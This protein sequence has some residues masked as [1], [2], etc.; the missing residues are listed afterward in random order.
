MDDTRHAIVSVTSEVFNRPS[1]CPIGSK[2]DKDWTRVFNHLRGWHW[3]HTHRQERHNA[4][5]LS[6]SQITPEEHSATSG[7]EQSSPPPA[8]RKFTGYPCN[9]DRSLRSSCSLSEAPRCGC[10]HHWRSLKHALADD[11]ALASRNYTSLLSF[12]A[13]QR[14]N[15]RPGSIRSNTHSNRTEFK[16]FLNHRSVRFDFWKDFKQHSSKPMN[17]DQKGSYQLSLEQLEYCYVSYDRSLKSSEDSW[18][19]TSKSI[20]TRELSTQHYE[21]TKFLT[22]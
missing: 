10:C 3:Q 13:H 14:S 7:S 22:D 12:F 16:R 6:L 17:S 2:N 9:L 4:A 18:K 20:W 15:I 19:W 21:L 8:S 5:S 1:H 11:I